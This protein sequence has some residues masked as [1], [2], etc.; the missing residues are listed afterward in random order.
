MNDREIVAAALRWHTAHAARLVVGA[1][2]R[3]EQQHSKQH[4]GYAS[5][6]S[7]T[8]KRHIEAKRLEMAAMRVLAK[9]CMRVRQ[10]HVTDIE[11]IDVPAVIR[12]LNRPT[13]QGEPT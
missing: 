1:E 5:A 2:K 11:A 8:D 9:A 12:Q 6:S 3:L 13:G 7:A 10:S 4:R